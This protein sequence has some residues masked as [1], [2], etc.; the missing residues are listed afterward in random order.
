MLV[1]LRGAAQ[2]ITIVY[3]DAYKPFAW[4]VGL[5]A[6]GVQRDFV[7]RILVDK[8]GLKVK[9]EV[10]PRR[11]AQTYVRD[12]ERD[13][14]FTVPT[15]ERASYTEATALPFYETNFVMHAA[16]SN[17]RA[18]A[19]RNVK[20]LQDLKAMREMRHIH[21][22]GSGWHMEALQGLPQVEQATDAS[23]IP[24]MLVNLRADV[25]I[26]QLEM[27][28]FQAAEQGLSEQI[29]SFPEVPL[30]RM[31]WHLFLGKKSPHRHLLPKINE[32]LRQM[33]ATGELDRVKREI[34]E[35]HGI[36]PAQPERAG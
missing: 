3:G 34:F 30:R 13:G 36:K 24:A 14:F 6:K 28:R 25:Y 31:G 18:A 21:M 7:Q 1:T 20:S 11:R 35:R 2:E 8:M 4:G 27:F 5:D 26:E 17:P 15:D 9:H 19:L 22:L 23:R 32:V 33:K 12:G 10:L 16:R 29:I